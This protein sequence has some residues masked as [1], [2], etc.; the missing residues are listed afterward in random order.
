MVRATLVTVVKAP[1]V[2]DFS[3]LVV[4]PIEEGLE[5]LSRL[6]QLGKPNQGGQVTLLAG[7]VLSSELY[8]C[9][10]SNSGDL[11]SWQSR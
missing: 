5:V 8:A 6:D 10:V 9:G 11:Y 7:Q 4:W 3:D 2:S 1:H